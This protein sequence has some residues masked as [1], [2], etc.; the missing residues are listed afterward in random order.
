MA[1][2]PNSRSFIRIV[3]VVCGILAAART[4]D[5]GVII[6]LGTAGCTGVVCGPLTYPGGLLT[7][8]ADGG[9][10]T[11]KTRNGATGL[12]IS[13]KTRGELDV[14]EFVRGSF[15]SPVGIDALTILFLYNG[16]EFDDPNEIAQISINGGA[17]VGT[18][19]ANA[20]NSA[21][22][23]LGGGGVTSCG[24]TSITGTGCFRIANPFASTFVSEIAFTAL[25][26]GN[27]LPNDSDFSLGSIEV[28]TAPEPAA[29]LLMG[30]GMLG[31]AARRR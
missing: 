2:L 4:A 20:E 22:W 7:L 5:A 19:T 31:V 12:G 11:S 15:S 10:F 1:P 23:S 30:L 16:G 18:L 9:T 26:A 6:D 8:T 14:N 3:V 21:V 24:D 13:G 29:L 17:V 25:S 27:S 28:A